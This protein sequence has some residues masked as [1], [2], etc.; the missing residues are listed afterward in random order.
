MDERIETPS[1]NLRISPPAEESRD[2]RR[3]VAH[4]DERVAELVRE[5]GA[6]A[7]PAARTGQ[8]FGGEL[9][10]GGGGSCR[11][12]A[13]GSAAGHGRRAPGWTDCARTLATRSVAAAGHPRVCGR[14]HAGARARHWRDV[15]DLRGG[16][17]GAA[18]AD[19]ISHADRLFVP[20]GEHLAAASSGERLLR[21]CEDWR[22]EEDAVCR[23]GAVAARGRRL[24]RRRVSPNSVQSRHCDEQDFPLVDVRPLCGPTLIPADM[25]RGADVILIS[26]DSLWPQQFGGAPTSSGQRD[27]SRACARRL[28]ACAGTAGL[29]RVVAAVSPDAP[30]ASRRR[31]PDASNNMIFIGLAVFARACRRSRP[32]QPRKSR[33]V[34]NRNF[35]SAKGWTTTLVPLRE[36]IVE[37]EVPPSALRAPGRG[38]GVLLIAC[39]NVANLALVRG[40]GRGGSWRSGLARCEPAAADSA[41][42]V[43]ARCSPLPA[44]RWGRVGAHLSCRAWCHRPG[45]D[46]V[47]E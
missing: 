6:R 1:G 26:H 40:S 15:R 13:R 17:R 23:S 44:R 22:R 5:A 21:G 18:A 4:L 19:A 42:L 28:S 10:Q 31:H 9:R 12:R 33:H 30:A 2:R 24:E 14:G 3:A 16:R 8:P 41:A 47:S 27:D 37:P 36:Y 29:A 11:A 35:P 32:A 38:S 39:A 46:A 45:G 7:R 34:S 20:V 25:Y 43:E